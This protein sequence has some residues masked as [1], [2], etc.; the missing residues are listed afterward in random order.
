MTSFYQRR[1]LA[2]ITP[3]ATQPVGV[4]LLRDSFLKLS[5]NSDD[6]MLEL[7]LSA[8]LEFIEGHLNLALITQSWRMTLD[9]WPGNREAWWNG[10]EVGH[11]NTITSVDASEQ[12]IPVFPLISVDSI[13]ADGAVVDVNQVFEVDT[14]REPGRIVLAF[15]RTWPVIT[16]L[17]A[18]AI[19]IEFTAGFGEN[20]EDVPGDVRLAI[21]K[22]A[23]YMYEHTGCEADEA[24]R[25]SG[26]RSLMS[27]YNRR[28][29]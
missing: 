25:K 28:K 14:T 2:R 10:V 7:L 19:V 21:T 18:N 1:G 26:A 20:P 8:S 5:D 17:T 13:T 27:N 12:E 23:E 11:I 9:H 22:M 24:Y 6:E 16:N 4:P 29:I 15:G 3:P